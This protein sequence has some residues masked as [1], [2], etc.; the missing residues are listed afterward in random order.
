[1]AISKNCR[2]HIEEHNEHYTRMGTHI[3]SSPNSWMK[4]RIPS[5]AGLTV[6]L[7]NAPGWHSKLN[8]LANHQIN[9]TADLETRLKLATRPNINTKVYL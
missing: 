8:K 1:M 5:N 4:T 9:M 7:T 6:V 2:D 3:P